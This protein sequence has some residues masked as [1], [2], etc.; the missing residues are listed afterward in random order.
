MKMT[1]FDYSKCTLTQAQINKIKQSIKYSEYKPELLSKFF[2]YKSL[3][4]NKLVSG[5][6]D[7][8]VQ[9][10]SEGK[11]AGAYNAIE[12]EMF[13]DGLID[14]TKESNED[15][16]LL[17]KDII[18]GFSFDCSVDDLRCSIINT[19]SSNTTAEIMI[20]VPRGITIELSGI[21]PIEGMRVIPQNIFNV[22]GS[23]GFTVAYRDQH[24]MVALD[25]SASGGIK[26][27]GDL[28]VYFYNCESRELVKD[29]ADKY[30]DVSNILAD[31][32]G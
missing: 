26:G 16:E 27:K 21:Q 13:P 22:Y 19:W 12:S 28:T 10:V 25:L 14:L 7:K 17:M 11:T 15:T 3:L 6:L 30:V 4:L 8:Y 23:E 5:E 2:D 18:R 32:R 9:P 29:R 24:S 31:F 1:T 20:H